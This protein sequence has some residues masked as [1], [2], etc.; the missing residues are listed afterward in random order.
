MKPV[1]L[2]GLVAPVAV[3]ILAGFVAL[4][5]GT[6]WAAT[7][8]AVGLGAIIGVH[9]WQIHRLVRWADA[10]LDA[11]VPEA[12]RRVGPRVLRALSPR[13]HAHAAP[14]RPRHDDRAFSQCRGSAARR[15]GD[16]RR[17]EPHPVGECAGA[18]APRPRP[19]EGHGPAA[20]QPDAPARSR[21][22]F[23]GRR[24]HR[25]R[26]C[27][28]A[29]RGR[30]DPFAPGRA[31][32]DRRAAAD[33]PRHHATGSRRAHA[34]RLH[35]QRLARAQDAADRRGRLSGD[36]AGARARAAPARAIPA[37]DGR[38]GHGACSASSTIC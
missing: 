6:G 35:R 28:F 1:F 36:A 22:L 12:R 38:A 11:Q 16:R 24:F 31:V 18:G 21:P 26:D 32:R 7:V 30:D 13:A 20:A 10:P 15:H 14:P 5:V 29:A 19:R 23:R 8:L 3:L 9:L 4:L 37:A 34:A 25:R 17:G 27:R 33:Q 2:T